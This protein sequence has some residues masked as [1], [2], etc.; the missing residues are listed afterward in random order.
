[1]GGNPC[2][3]YVFCYP[4]YYLPFNGDIEYF[5]FGGDFEGSELIVHLG[6]HM[7]HISS[8]SFMFCSYYCMLVSYRAFCLHFCFVFIF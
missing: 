7:L 5:K 4:L 3:R 1:M 8:N 6:N 2:V